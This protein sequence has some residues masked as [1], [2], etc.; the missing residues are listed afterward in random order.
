MSIMEV[1]FLES[2]L[3][4]ED[5]PEFDAET[6]A[7]TFEGERCGICMDIIID[8]GVLDCCQHWF[9]FECIDNWSSITNLCPLCQN[10]FQLITCVPVYDT[11]GSS[12]TDEGSHP[13]DDDWFVEGKNNTLSFP[14]YYIDENA[15]TCL[16]G[17]GCKIRNEL[18]TLEEDLTLDTSIACDSCDTWYH[19]FCVGFDP[20]GNVDSW[21]CPR[22]VDDGTTKKSVLKLIDGMGNL[23]HSEMADNNCLVNMLSGKVSISVADAGETAVV[24]S[25]IDGKQVVEEPFEKSLSSTEL[26]DDHKTCP[27][28]M[29]SD[30]FVKSETLSDQNIT[31]ILP[32]ADAEKL[33][34]CISIDASLILPCNSL[35]LK[36]NTDDEGMGKLSSFDKS[37]VLSANSY[38]S[39]IINRRHDSERI[40]SHN[41]VLG[42]SASG[43]ESGK[44]TVQLGGDEQHCST[45]HRNFCGIFPADEHVSDAKA[46]VA[47]IIGEKRVRIEDSNDEKQVGLS[48]EAS[49]EKEKAKKRV[50]RAPCA[51]DDFLKPGH[52]IPSPSDEYVERSEKNSSLTNIM[53]IVQGTEPRIV[54]GLMQG[55]PFDKFL[56]G[57]KK[58]AGLRMKKI[59]RRPAEDKESSILVQNLRKEIREAIRDKSSEDIGKSI[60]DPKLLAAFR[61]AVTEPI[62]G[63][64]RKVCSPIVK[65]KKSILQKGKTREKLTKKIY[66]TANGKRRRAWDRE[67]EVEFWKH[68][69]IKA[70]KPEK[71]DM[72][73]SVLD[74]LRKSPETKH[75]Q[76]SS[77]GEA[78][79]PILSRLYLADASV[80]PRKDDIKPL[81]VFKDAAS[82]EQNE[83]LTSAERDT[84]ASIDKH[85][86]GT[87]SKLEV[88]L[89][90]GISSVDIKNNN[91]SGASTKSGVF[92]NKV[93]LG[94]HFEKSSCNLSG[95]VDLH[96]EATGKSDDK[97][98]NKR[99]WAL[100]V[101]ARKTGSNAKSSM[102]QKQEDDAV[103]KGN[104]PLL[105]QLPLD[106]RPKLESS[107][108][109]K[110]PVAV[111][112]TQLYRLTE[113]FLRMANPACIC[114]TAAT[115]LAIADAINIEKMVADKSKSKVVYLNLCSQELRH[116][117]NSNDYYKTAKSN[118]SSPLMAPSE[119]GEPSMAAPSYDPEAEAALRAAGLLS[120]SPPTSP[121]HREEDPNHDADR[122]SEPREIRP[123]NV[124]ELGSHPELDIYGD[125]VYN[126]EDEDY[127]GGAAVDVSKLQAA[128]VETKMKLV[129]STPNMET[130]FPTFGVEDCDAARTDILASSSCRCENDKSGTLPSGLIVDEGDEEPSLSECK[131]IYGPDKEP[132][133]KSLAEVPTDVNNHGSV[134][135]IK[136]PALDGKN[137]AAKKSDTDVNGGACGGDN[138]PCHSQTGENIHDEKPPGTNVNKR[139]DNADSIVKKVEAYIKEHIRPL[140]RSG[141]ITVEQYRWAVRKTAEKVM[142]YH[143]K[144]KNANFLIKEGDKVKKLAE[145]YVEAANHKRIT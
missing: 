91:G 100:E 66:A 52:Q 34:Q 31:T 82:F 23:C 32:D 81:S 7:S 96:K 119:G 76:Q 75:F 132:I 43:E 24:V 141:V 126:L 129:F 84:K 139:D 103:L 94:R 25:L 104:Y 88:P 125:F 118:P 106:M 65:A 29:A 59:M 47:A 46:D 67:C 85:V 122:L 57:G 130:P 4:E 127:I 38:D 55:K 35:E 26:H 2:G 102:D 116:H 117:L 71:I 16:D 60:F 22:C 128:E 69:C 58:A 18:V 101:L 54:N 36:S 140:C 121:S 44:P 123:D 80:L 136:S 28:K 79:N 143:S 12:R 37:T 111:R 6:D 124:F 73:K 110:I 108:H 11:I 107:Q 53:S 41:L 5:I 135:E 78:R 115:E 20:E 86:D 1:E 142:K 120:D 13:R 83:V 14:S 56:T 145:Q 70:T 87:L 77:E 134:E 74:L 131:E 17:D 62:S 89:Q 109:N 40:M 144:A 137:V 19:A 133:I 138:S 113:H 51:L 99:K 112:Q 8:R 33:A 39:C 114:R 50:R 98:S 105:A 10:E 42:S 3:S 64:I 72:L 49:L 63:P 97:I 92:S 30:A 15:V 68:R 48:T 90:S 9:C 21:L 95:V 93:K 45:S 27:S 61:A